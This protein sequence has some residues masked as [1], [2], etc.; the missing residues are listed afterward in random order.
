[1]IS[2][3]DVQQLRKDFENLSLKFKGKNIAASSLFF[4]ADIDSQKQTYQFSILENDAK[5]PQKPDEIRL[6]QND[7]FVF[8]QI[9]VGYVADIQLVGRGIPPEFG[10][11]IFLQ[12]VPYSTDT[13]TARAYKLFAGQLKVTINN[14]IYFEKYDLRDFDNSQAED[15]FNQLNGILSSNDVLQFKAHSRPVF[16]PVQPMIAMSGAK[17]NEFEIQ[18]PSAIDPWGF[19]V[20]TNPILPYWSFSV[21]RIGILL[22]G[23]L[24]QNA[25]KFQI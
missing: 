14:Y 15:Q 8:N 10:R 13:Q 16:Q 24:I 25:A 12:K 2:N 11:S 4:T 3:Y 23:F 7:V 6:N 5:L 1:M 20:M 19:S 17:K 9:A 21:N 22:R 18:L